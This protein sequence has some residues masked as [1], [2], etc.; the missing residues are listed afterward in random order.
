MARLQTFATCFVP[1]QLNPV[2]LC[3]PTSLSCLCALPVLQHSRHICEA[4][5][6]SKTRRQSQHA[7]TSI[8]NNNI[9]RSLSTYD[10]LTGS[11]PCSSLRSSKQSL[12]TSTVPPE[13]ATSHYDYPISRRQITLGMATS[14]LAFPVATAQPPAAAASKLPAFADSAWE[15]MGGGPSDLF[16]PEGFAGTWDVVSTL[17]KVDTPLGEDI[18]PD[19]RM[20]RRAQQED[21]GHPLTYQVGMCFTCCSTSQSVL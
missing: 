10:S 7:S 6:H 20:L 9:D 19:I 3:R 13:V 4:D 2:W 12:H 15:A 18:L 16:F 14:L 21:L 11:Q 17:V 8:T 5:F 1:F